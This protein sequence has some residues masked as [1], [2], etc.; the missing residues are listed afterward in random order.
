M[1]NT[2]ASGIDL[3]AFRVD[4]QP[5]EE[6]VKPFTI[7]CMPGMTFRDF[8]LLYLGL[9]CSG[10]RLVFPRSIEAH[11]RDIVILYGRDTIQPQRETEYASKEAVPQGLPVGLGDDLPFVFGFIQEH[12]RTTI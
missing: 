7:S 2:P 12:S 9:G 3:R 6:R 4:R 5:P 1:F 11:L 8:K 10:V